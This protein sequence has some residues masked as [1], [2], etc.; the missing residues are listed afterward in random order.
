V[1]GVTVNLIGLSSLNK[2]ARIDGDNYCMA[3]TRGTWWSGE[4]DVAG[5]SWG[6]FP[7]SFVHAVCL[8]AGQN[9][10]RPPFYLYRLE[11]VVTGRCHS[12]LRPWRLCGCA[13]KTSVFSSAKGS[14]RLGLGRAHEVVCAVW[15]RS[16]KAQP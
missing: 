8:S 7:L 15:C 1:C 14:A 4:V 6:S 13:W 9:S 2:V 10:P 16:P 11:V 3:A 5:G 12:G